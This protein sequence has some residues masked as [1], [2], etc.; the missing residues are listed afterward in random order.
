MMDTFSSVVELFHVGTIDYE[1]KW[2][3]FYISNDN[4]NSLD[5]GEVKIFEVK[6]GSVEDEFLLIKDEKLIDKLY[7]IF[8]EEINFKDEGSLFGLNDEID[9]NLKKTNCCLKKC[10]NKR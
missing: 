7:E 1:N 2:Y 8:I 6:K 5:F 9:K 10:V 3:A 4:F